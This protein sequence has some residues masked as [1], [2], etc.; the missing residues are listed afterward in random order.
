VIVEVPFVYRARVQFADA[1]IPY[2]KIRSA[3]AVFVPDAPLAD[4]PLVLSGHDGR[5]P[6]EIRMVGSRYMKRVKTDSNS[7][8]AGAI[9]FAALGRFPPSPRHLWPGTRTR[10]PNRLQMTE[11]NTIVD[12][13]DPRLS[14]IV[15][16][17]KQDQIDTLVAVAATMFAATGDAVWKETGEPFIRIANSDPATALHAMSS[18]A[19]IGSDEGCPHDNIVPVW[20]P[21]LLEIV[22]SWC[23]EVN[24]ASW[25]RIDYFDRSL[26][27]TTFEEV[28]A[29]RLG[30][31]ANIVA[32]PE[33]AN[34]ALYAVAECGQRS[35]AGGALAAISGWTAREEMWLERLLA[36]AART[37]LELMAIP[38]HDVDDVAS[39]AS[40]T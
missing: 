26:L 2:R 19:A 22:K 5:N 4:S 15:E 17:D 38:D 16:S 25:C 39:L 9:G 1:S 23:K 13:S 28:A 24:S 3:A 7:S 33:D 14:R 40:L 32:R 21:D 37:T 36:S 35:D 31:L 8:V 12:E 6:V 30:R 10:R 29:R 11:W 27:P 20:R 34:T 18:S